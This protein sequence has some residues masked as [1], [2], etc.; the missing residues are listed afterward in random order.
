MIRPL[1]IRR[2]LF[3]FFFRDG[4]G[5]QSFDGFYL[6]GKPGAFLR[7]G[8]LS[9]LMAR[10]YGFLTSGTSSATALISSFMYV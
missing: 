2:D 5:N 1:E 3:V 7:G 9:G 8:L 6:V 4:Y 10:P